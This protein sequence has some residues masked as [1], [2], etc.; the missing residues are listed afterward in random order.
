MSG[1]RSPY[2]TRFRVLT[3]PANSAT[4]NVTPKSNGISQA[5]K[6][7]KD[8]CSDTDQVQ[9]KRKIKKETKIEIKQEV[10]D[11]FN[12]EFPKPVIKWEP[13]NWML[14]LNNIRKMRED[15]NAPIDTM[16]CE[17]C[18]GENYSEKD[19]RFHL[20]VSLMLSSQTKDHVTHA[21]MLR[22]IDHGLSVESVLKM[23]DSKLGDLIYPVGFWKKKI[24]YLKRTAEVLKKEYDCD[25]PNSVEDLVKLPGVGPKMAYLTMTCAWNKVVG[26]GVDVHVHRIANR[27]KWVRKQTSE[28]EKTR[29]ELED[30]LPQ[31]YWREVNW[32]LVGFGQQI[33]LPINPRCS[34]CLNKDICPS[35]SAKSRKLKR[36]HL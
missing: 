29:K 35:S 36:E 6:M 8:S 31:S 7:K 25:I 34:D 2:F 11:S 27:L 19:K 13:N 12:D 20:L 17:K 21:A 15:K 4:A 18:K 5:K 1:T 28:P 16:G 26:I 9:T 33:C 24:S 10:I 14:L 22:L 23:Q 30:W 32:L 3:V